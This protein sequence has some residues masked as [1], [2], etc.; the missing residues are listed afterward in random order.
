MK[1]LGL[2]CQKT[3]SFSFTADFEL[4]LTFLLFFIPFFPF[5][6]VS[7]PAECFLSVPLLLSG[8]LNADVVTC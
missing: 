1:L 6:P 3:F 2:V 7:T 8:P 5:A 4:N